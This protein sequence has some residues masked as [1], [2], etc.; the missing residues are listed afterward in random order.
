MTLVKIKKAIGII[1]GIFLLFPVV[2]NKAL[3]KEGYVIRAKSGLEIRVPEK[4][5]DTVN[6]NP[7]D[8]KHSCLEI[9]NTSSGKLMV[10]IRTDIKDKK[11]PNGGHLQEVMTLKIKDGEDIIADNTFEAVK[12]KGNIYIGEMAPSSK[13]T[14]CFYTN[15]PEDIG[16]E[17]QGASFKANWVF[18][19]QSLGGGDGDDDPHKPKPPKDKDDD[20]P[21]R[22]PNDDDKGPIVEIED[23]PI[24]EGPV[25]IDIPSEL[26]EIVIEDDEIPTGPVD[27]PATGM[28]SPWNY[29][30]IGALTIMLGITIKDKN[31]AGM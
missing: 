13:K 21:S 17:Y 15:L 5:Q 9:K 30:V 19:T 25:E 28:T 10:Y 3:A 4:T 11:S 18:T 12:E 31:Q 6:L 24:P 22:P 29:Y 7:G 23:E 16:N 2:S 26:E 1:F 14:I 27:M 20:T 8:K